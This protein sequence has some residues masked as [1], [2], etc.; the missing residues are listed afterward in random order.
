[1]SFLLCVCVCAADAY[2]WAVLRVEAVGGDKAEGD[3]QTLVR[4]KDL[5]S[6]RTIPARKISLLR[7][8]SDLKIVFGLLL[9]ANTSKLK[10]RPDK[11]RVKVSDVSSASRVTQVSDIFSCRN[12]AGFTD[13]CQ[14]DRN[15]LQVS[16]S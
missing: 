2:F 16:L 5:G 10:L 8:I 1:M 11:G 4:A 6:I 9:G 15:Q 7:H 12:R 3:V 14:D 13:F